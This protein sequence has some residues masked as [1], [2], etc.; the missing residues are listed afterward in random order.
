MLS[1]TVD[2]LEH[3]TEEGKDFIFSSYELLVGLVYS[4]AELSCEEGKA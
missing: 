2:I 3:Q 4:D 1:T